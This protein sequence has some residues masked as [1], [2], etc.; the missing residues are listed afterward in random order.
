MESGDVPKVTREEE[1]ELDDVK[2]RQ[3][4]MVSIGKYFRYRHLL[5]I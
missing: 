3:K 2:M 5:P 4:W 1:V